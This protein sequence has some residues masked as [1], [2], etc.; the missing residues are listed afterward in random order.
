[1]EADRG[2]RAPEDF[3]NC[4]ILFQLRRRGDDPVHPPLDEKPRNVCATIP[5]VSKVADQGDKAMLTR[6]LEMPP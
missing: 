2:H 4:E 1:M 6:G 3:G 5:G